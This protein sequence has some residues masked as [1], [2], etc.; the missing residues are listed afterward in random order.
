MPSGSCKQDDRSFGV[1]AKEKLDNQKVIFAEVDVCGR[2][3]QVESTLWADLRCPQ[4]AFLRWSH[5]QERTPYI[6]SAKGPKLRA[7]NFRWLLLSGHKDRFDRNKTT[8]QDES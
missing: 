7:R 5:F 8:Y 4:F 6:E 1:P 2:F 3:S